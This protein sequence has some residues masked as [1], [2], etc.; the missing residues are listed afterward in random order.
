MAEYSRRKKFQFGFIL[1]LLSLFASLLLAEL[2]IRVSKDYITPGIIRERSLEYE[3]AVFA[4]HVFPLREHE[5]AD[6]GWYINSLGY[7]GRPFS[8]AKSSGTIRIIVYG[9]SAVFDTNLPQGRDWPHRIEQLLQERGVDNVEVIN[10]GIPGHASFDSFGRFFA[11][12]HL[13]EPDYVLLYQAWNDIKHFA[14]EKPLLRSIAPYVPKHDFR[15]TYQGTLDKVLCNVSQLYVRLRARHYSRK[16]TIGFE[17]IIPDGNQTRNVTEIGLRQYRLNME[18]FV[19]LARNIQAQP[20]LITQARLV[21]RDNTAE[22]QSRIRYEYLG[23]N[24]ETILQ[25]FQETD[26]I[27]SSVSVSKSTHFVDAA[28]LFHGQSD[29][30]E[31]HVHLSATGSE[32][33]AQILSEYLFGLINPPGD[34][35]AAHRR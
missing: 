34:G 23:M 15:S 4:R 30:F 17:G 25:A 26:E 20:I 9:G 11:E 31:D 12:G 28:T 1:L 3:P 35:P 22:E 5:V 13:F 32:H 8:T 21:R 18:M 10:A 29:Y 7:R 14:M 19:D 24:Q 27:V 2:Y 6:S 33:L 16:Y